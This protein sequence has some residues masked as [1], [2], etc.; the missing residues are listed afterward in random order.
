VWISLSPATIEFFDRVDVRAEPN[1]KVHWHLHLTLDQ[2]AHRRQ[3]GFHSRDPP[4]ESW[5]D[6]VKRTQTELLE[7]R[8]QHLGYVPLPI[9]EIL[10]SLAFITLDWLSV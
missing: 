9:V 10:A 4:L 7:V 3:F 6:T 2:P 1:A 8:A 5:G